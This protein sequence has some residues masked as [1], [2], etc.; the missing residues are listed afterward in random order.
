MREH[1]RA[2]GLARRGPGRRICRRV[3][4]QWATKSGVLGKRHRTLTSAD[5][6]S[7]VVISE[8][9]GL[10]KWRLAVGKASIPWVL[11]WNGEARQRR[12]SGGCSGRWVLWP[13]WNRWRDR[14]KVG[15][16]VDDDDEH[17]PLGFDVG[18]A[19]DDAIYV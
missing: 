18:F 2:E 7:C 9:A 16:L 4:L 11:Y 10:V 19:P 15:Y 1:V 5:R 3:V 6:C 12:S 17:H 14:A 13:G 8:G